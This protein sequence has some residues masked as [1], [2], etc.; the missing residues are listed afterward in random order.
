M[1]KKIFKLIIKGRSKQRN[2]QFGSNKKG[3]EG[4]NKNQETKDWRKHN[5]GKLGTYGKK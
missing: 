3:K 4:D 1:Y 2:C 5:K